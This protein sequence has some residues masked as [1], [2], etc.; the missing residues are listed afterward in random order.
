MKFTK[1]T[2][3]DNRNYGIDL[4][5]LM[6]MFMIVILHV[7]EHGGIISEETELTGH[8][9]VFSWLLEIMAYC[10][11]NC[12]A[13]VS[14]YVSY[15]DKER[16]YHYKRYI[17]MWIQVI[18]YSFGITFIAFLA[19]TESIG[20]KE[21]IRSLFPVTM[22]QYW[23]FSAYTAVF[24][25][26]PML[27]AFVRSCTEKEL[28][29]Y[30]LLMFLVFS[31]YGRMNG[32]FSDSFQLNGGYSVIWLILLYICGAWLKKCKIAQYVKREHAI[33]LL[34][35]CILLTWFVK[36]FMPYGNNLFISYVSPTVVLMA[37]CYVILFSEISITK[38]IYKRLI[39]N[40][41]PAAFGVY[42]IHD[43]KFVRDMLISGRFAWI[44]KSP[45]WLL[46]LQVLGCAGGIFI[47]CLFIEKVRIQLF[48][49]LKIDQ[50]VTSFANYVLSR[51]IR[52][53]FF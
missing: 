29:K 15:T 37:V 53:R 12:F 7:M 25:V 34:I 16:E 46:P 43:H 17:T 49:L 48:G 3:T 23:Y 40:F 30:I 35:A 42:L 18:T 50:R 27:N 13:I 44:A 22:N 8:Q 24:F 47:L 9:Y 33:V 20:I 39:R 38:D 2:I 21:I 1:E 45:V 51:K 26:V 10:A 11:V 19:G 14:G 36:I 32:H 31:C 5:R 6:A 4:L 41:A 28:N 52:Q